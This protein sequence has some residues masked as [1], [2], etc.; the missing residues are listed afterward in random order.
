MEGVKGVE[1][2]EIGKDD[3]SFVWD[4]TSQ[5]YFHARSGFYHDPSAG[6][7]YSSKDGQYYKFENGSYTLLEY[8]KDYECESHRC[9]EA[10]S[11]PCN[12][13]EDESSTQVHCKSYENISSFPADQY[14]TYPCNGTVSEENTPGYEKCNIDQATENPPPPSEW[15]EETLINLYLSGYKQAVNNT[16]VS[17][18]YMEVD[19]GDEYSFPVDGIS[20]DNAQTSE[21]GGWTSEHQYSSVDQ[22]ESIVNE[23]AS[24]DEENWRSQ[25]GQVVHSGE[26]SMQDIHV[27]DLWD[28]AMVTGSKK[29]KKGH[30]ARLVGRLVRQS[31]KFHPSM[32]SSGG[33]FRTAPICET[34]LNL[35]RV[36][37]GQVYQLRN[38]S[39]RY[40][41]S[42]SN[43][44][45][46]NPTKDWGFPEFSLNVQDSP[47][48][49]SGGKSE[50]KLIDEDPNCKGMFISPNGLSTS[51]KQRSHEYRDR[52]AERRSLHGGFGVGPGQK[53]S[54]FNDIS[55]ST[56]PV[57]SSTEEAAAEALNMSFG[58]GSY[59][60]KILENM[61]W[62]EGE[63][64]GNTR[65]GLIKPIEAVGNVGNA[66]LGWPH[67]RKG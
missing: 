24:R 40:L 47:P 38:P 44:D 42:L 12:P 60:R 22:C 2:Q 23:E 34:Y 63:A 25:Y 18:T 51:E 49:K 11:E 28:W 8:N 13:V 48:T 17:K 21:D 26:Q 62:K 57:S 19:D 59:A 36:R 56:S 65:K 66:G 4:E 10:V 6:W 39:A 58:A 64:L 67:S 14:D 29:D 50:Q 1:S 32:P 16:D 31:V 7:Y 43:Y 55:G 53:S 41:T 15:L 20:Y 5:L 54:L 33:V 35:V 3:C 9:S 27:V 46:S 61:G 52:A 30:A 45:S 37:T